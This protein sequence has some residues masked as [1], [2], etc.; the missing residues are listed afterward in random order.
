MKDL[1][2][3][4]SESIRRVISKIEVKLPIRSLEP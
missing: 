3:S 2:K 1:R 4:I